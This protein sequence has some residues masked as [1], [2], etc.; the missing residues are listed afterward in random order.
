[1]K[2]RSEEE[3]LA[4]VREKADVFRRRRR[5][6]N[7][8]A[9]GALVALLLVI[10]VLAATTDGPEETTVTADAGMEPTQEINTSTTATSTAP[11]PESEQDG[12]SSSAMSET[13]APTTVHPPTTADRGRDETS[14]DGRPGASNAAFATTTTTAP[15]PPLCPAWAVEMVV[16]TERS[17]YIPGEQVVITAKGTN[18]AGHDCQEA[19]S[20]ETMIRNQ[21]GRQ[22]YRI[23][24]IAARTQGD[25]RWRAGE[26][27]MSEERWNQ[28]SITENGR[29]PVPPGTYT[30]TIGWSAANPES[31]ER[32]TYTSSATFTIEQ[33]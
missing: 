30:V 9:G 33:P 17:T 25:W 1:M 23:A 18:H 13:A 20:S 8:A 32:V 6:V 21:E 5:R 15:R 2:L 4:L 14:D 7:T 26:S 22:V 31:G 19:E 28:E 12:A 16:A 29:S 3:L 27:R 11:S 10:S 24:T